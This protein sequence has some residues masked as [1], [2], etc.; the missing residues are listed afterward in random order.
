MW[1]S[2]TAPLPWIEQTSS[3]TW[4]FPLE[5]APQNVFSISNRVWVLQALGTG[6]SSKALQREKT[7]STTRRSAGLTFRHRLLGTQEQKGFCVLFCTCKP[8][9]VQD[10]WGAKGQVCF[11]CSLPHAHPGTRCA[12]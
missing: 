4:A 2:A 6:V 3:T 8:V 1:G 9:F 11:I 12:V 10:L 5:G 7:A